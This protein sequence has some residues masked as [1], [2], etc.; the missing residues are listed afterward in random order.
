MAK[1]CS[2][3]GTVLQD[4]YWLSRHMSK[5]A[6]PL[7]DLETGEGRLIKGY[8]VSMLLGLTAAIVGVA[9]TLLTYNAAAPGELYFLWYGPAI[10][11]ALAFLR[12]FTECLFRAP[13]TG[14]LIAVVVALGIFSSVLGTDLDSTLIKA[15][16]EE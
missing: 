1:E 9:V 13:R 5:H 2:E 11:G 4:D 16:K 8:H 6:T 12:G 14:L 10:F 7:V 15:I 3:C